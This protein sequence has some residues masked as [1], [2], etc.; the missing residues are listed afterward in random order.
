MTTLK[1]DD[2]EYT[3]GRIMIGPG[4]ALDEADPKQAPIMFVALCLQA[5]GHTEATPEWVKANFPRWIDGAPAIGALMAKGY[6]ANG[7]QTKVPV[8]GESQPA[9]PAQ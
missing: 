5:G 7:V 1:I 8:P 3:F 9:G 4:E 6:E 2:K